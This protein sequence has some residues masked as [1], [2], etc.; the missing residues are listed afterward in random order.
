MRRNSRNAQKSGAGLRRNGRDAQTDG[1]GL[2]RG[3]RNAGRAGQGC[4]ESAAQKDFFRAGTCGN[5][6]KRQSAVRGELPGRRSDRKTRKKPKNPE[7][8]APGEL[9]TGRRGKRKTRRK[10]RRKHNSAKRRKMQT[11]S[12]KNAREGPAG[13]D[14]KLMKNFTKGEA[15]FLWNLCTK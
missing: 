11:Q 9:R 4:D 1:A 10:K 3:E 14:N 5:G 13:Q 8:S 15:R 7:K 2:R 12:G 6:P